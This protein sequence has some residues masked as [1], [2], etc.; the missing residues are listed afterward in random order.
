MPVR[1]ANIPKQ[2]FGGI[3]PSVSVEVAV[4][5][6]A[7]DADRIL[8]SQNGVSVND[9]YQARWDFLDSVF[10]GNQNETVGSGCISNILGSVTKFFVL[11]IIGAVVVSVIDSLS[12]NDDPI[13]VQDKAPQSQPTERAKPIKKSQ[14]S[15]KT[16]SACEIWAAANPALASKLRAGDQCYGEF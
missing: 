4:G 13:D 15:E 12:E 5:V 6:S 10:G 2:G 14:P 8:A 9:L 1:T 3:G 11:L 16:L 7:E